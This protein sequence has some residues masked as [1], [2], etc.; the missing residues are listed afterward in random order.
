MSSKH[1]EKICEI[2]EIV[3]DY[4]DTPEQA[5]EK[6]FKYD[7]A[8]SSVEEIDIYVQA[9]YQNIFLR[10]LG[11]KRVFPGI[12]YDTIIKNLKNP[13]KKIFEKT[14][15]KL[16][17]IGNIKEG[18]V[19]INP[20]FRNLY[21]NLKNGYIL[22]D[23]HYCKD[24]KVEVIYGPNSL[25]F[26]GVE[27]YL[28]LSIF[29]EPWNLFLVFSEKDASRLGLSLEENKIITN[30]RIKDHLDGS[31]SI[32]IFKPEK[33]LSFGTQLPELFSEI[34]ESA[35]KLRILVTS[36]FE[37]YE[38]AKLVRDRLIEKLEEMSLENEDFYKKLEETK[39][40]DQTVPP[41]MPLSQIDSNYS[42]LF[43]SALIELEDY[44]KEREKTMEKKRKKFIEMIMKK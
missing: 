11:F 4:Y 3:A 35:E 2:L 42:M 24:L 19:G 15:R 16:I 40:V 26:K 14:S 10:S 12:E 41:N 20:I 43:E 7:G 38:K 21:D 33:K 23:D 29:E 44:I 30:Y 17:L 31:V 27:L 36:R 25:G 39:K 32:E 8:P 37:P 1:F 6:L 9:I 22:R 28:S 18:M 34:K 5:L 13:L